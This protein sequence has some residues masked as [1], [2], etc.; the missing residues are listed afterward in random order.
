[1]LL[2]EPEVGLRYIHNMDETTVK[3]EPGQ[4]R[5]HSRWWR[6]LKWTAVGAVVLLL[7]AWLLVVVLGA[8][9]IKNAI[10]HVGPLALG[11][12]VSVKDVTF[13]PLR[14]LVRLQGLHV[15]NPEGFKTPALLDLQEVSVLFEPR[16]L[17]RPPFHI[18]S[19]KV[20]DPVITYELALGK[21]NIGALQDSLE[22]DA[23]K[24][25]EA[26]EGGAKGKVIIDEVVVEGARVRL[27]A[28]L[29][30]GAAAGIPLPRIALH[31]IG[32][33]KGGASWLEASTS[34]L[35]AIGG[36]IV[37]AVTGVGGALVEGVKALGSGLGGLLSGHASS[38]VTNT[39]S[40]TN[41]TVD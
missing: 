10:N 20:R 35:K 12:P 9:I 24:K 36:A 31:D 5:R 40:S 17:L 34:I 3:L 38:A 1:M 22:G 11:V 32:K 26:G 13:R 27:S 37:K 23:Q 2:I 41:A 30:Q 14:G 7:A 39:A 4:T 25:E 8:A 6:I 18:K 16:S 19:I 21:S 29:F 33:E 28:T 15:G